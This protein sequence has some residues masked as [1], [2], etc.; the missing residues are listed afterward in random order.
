[1]T[2]L[3]QQVQSAIDELVDDGSEV[4]L[5]VA[6]LHRGELIVD[7][8]AGTR[9]AARAEPVGPDTLF[10]SAST[11]KGI[12]SAVAHALVE[13]GE[14]TYDLRAAEVW[15]EFARHGKDGVTLRHV[16]LHTAGVPAPPYD[17][18]LEQLCDWDHMCAV[19]A[20]AEPWWP[21]G[22]R[23]GYHALTFGFLVGELVRRATG[24]SITDRLRDAVTEPLGVA[25]DVH[26]GVPEPLLGR[27]AHQHRPVAPL[28]RPK[29]GSPGDRAMPPGLRMDADAANRRD[30]LTSDIVSMGTVTARGA[31]TVYGG[32][33]GPVDGVRLVSPER[34]TALATPAYEG[35]D[36]VMNVPTAWAFGFGPHRPPGGAPGRSG[37]VFGMLGANGSAAYADI[38]SGVAVAVLRNLFSVD[39]SAAATVDRLVAEALSR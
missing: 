23:F 28:P 4:G 36:E 25:A 7:A 16:L 5:Q 33:L 8:V 35:L 10:W 32:L 17:T 20:D 27:V 15:P 13:R 24:R 30:V 9:D 2:T 1:M 26:F 18:T 38:D 39:W 3:Q 6:V 14:L 19:L 12:A 11:V 22:T 37:S 34:L 21:A 31:A 29:P